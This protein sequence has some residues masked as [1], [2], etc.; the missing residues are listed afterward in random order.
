MTNAAF[1]EG[2]GPILLDDMMCNGLE[3]KLFDCTHDGLEVNNCAHYQDAGVV[4]VAGMYL[5]KI[6]TWEVL[7]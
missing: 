2:T 7:W 3:Y 6:N 1:G 5:Y 4:C